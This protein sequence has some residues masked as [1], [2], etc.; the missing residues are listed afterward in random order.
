[1]RRGGGAGDEREK[2]AVM[3]DTRDEHDEEV[4]IASARPGSLTT[5]LGSN[6]EQVGDLLF[7]KLAA[8]RRVT[9]VRVTCSSTACGSV[10]GRVTVHGTCSP[11]PTVRNNS[12]LANLICDFP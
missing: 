8:P 4:R 9:R 3:M 11:C 2:K 10:R 6:S 12:P 5:C 7:G 1:M